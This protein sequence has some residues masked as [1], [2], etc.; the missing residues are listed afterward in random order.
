MSVPR[1][2]TQAKCVLVGDQSAGKR[3]LQLTFID[4]EFPAYI[5]T[6]LEQRTVEITVRGEPV[7][8]QIWNITG[9]EELN[10]RWRSLNYTRTDV[11][12][13]CYSVDDRQ[14][15]ENIKSKWAVEINQHCPD[16]IKI[17]VATK[18]DLRW[19][20]PSNS[21]TWTTN[22]QPRSVSD[23]VTL[24]G[25]GGGER[26]VSF[27]MV[28]QRFSLD[29]SR[30]MTSIKWNRRVSS[31]EECFEPGTSLERVVKEFGAGVEEEG[32]YGLSRSRRLTITGDERFHSLYE[33][34]TG[35]E[36][37]DD[38]EKQTFVLEKEGRKLMQQ[39]EFDAFLECS[40][41]TGRGVNDVFDT[42]ARL[43][44]WDTAKKRKNRR[45]KLKDEE[46]R[47]EKEMKRRF[48]LNDLQ[49]IDSKT[50][51]KEKKKEFKAMKKEADVVRVQ[52]DWA[53]KKEKKEREKKKR[54]KNKEDN[55]GHKK[56][57]CVLS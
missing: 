34:A 20:D 40:A 6:V 38:E 52:T 8:L 33:T 22:T 18:R 32:G 1:K 48:L 10:A 54:E 16:A 19:D 15:F 30:M 17:L 44:L 37:G 56:G 12:L 7:S 57:G 41:L 5:P 4:G 46:E 31:S 39:L 53:A 55:E 29:D 42:A 47:K 23:P 43:V 45:K 51:W 25:G 9:Q 28:N 36:D 49:Q 26:T 3:C 2:Q 35:V 13:L 27:G 24:S 50:F 21:G 14:S 11:A